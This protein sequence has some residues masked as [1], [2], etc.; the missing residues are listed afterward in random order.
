ME[1]KIKIHNLLDSMINFIISEEGGGW[2]RFKTWKEEN[3]PYSKTKGVNESQ[4]YDLR[5]SLKKDIK[6]G[7]KYELKVN[8]EK[9]FEKSVFLFPRYKEYR[10]EQDN[11]KSRDFRLYYF[12][13]DKNT[14][15]PEMGR[16][17]VNIINEK[18]VTIKNFNDKRHFYG[19]IYEEMN[20][21][22]INADN[23]RKVNKVTIHMK[24][25]SNDYDNPLHLGAYITYEEGEI[26]TGAMIMVKDTYKLD[27]AKGS[28]LVDSIK[29]ANLDKKDQL[30]LVEEEKQI[31]R[32]LQRRSKSF[33]RIPSS[34]QNFDALMK[35][36]DQLNMKEI[37][38]PLRRFISS[39]TKKVHL[40]SPSNFVFDDSSNLEMLHN[41]RKRLGSLADVVIP[42]EET[43][44]YD[45]D[46]LDPVK[47][48]S[49]MEN[50]DVFV[51]IYTN[52]DHAS[53]SLVELGYAIHACKKCM[54]FHE[55]PSLSN[56]MKALA[57][58]GLVS[59]HE[60]PVKNVESFITKKIKSALLS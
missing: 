19:E 49:G 18:R 5:R 55:G 20:S 14:P 39:K 36:S 60:L 12:H 22:V 29:S 42:L 45:V 23:R 25:N 54:L 47:T 43:E 7:V 57:N 31:L 51:L 59:R 27:P 34:V 32:Y 46:E 8:D 35:R 4:L 41:I 58:K 9:L 6:E 17:Q 26:R 52:T 1:S 11:S 44:K 13:M 37:T 15:E 24:F 10:S 28:N 38:N 30:K 50:T 56:Q 40:A 53:F 2:D 3:Y 16:L 33:L 21:L 48:F